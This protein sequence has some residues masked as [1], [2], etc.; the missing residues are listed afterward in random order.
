VS[1]AYRTHL[2]N[3]DGSAACGARGAV[4]LVTTNHSQITC[5]TCLKRLGLPI[6]P[7]PPRAVPPPRARPAG[8]FSSIAGVSHPNDD[9][10]SRQQIIARCR[11][12]E[13]LILRADPSN[14]YD[15]SAV[16]V[17]RSS[18]EQLGYLHAYIAPD[19][20][21]DL[22]NGIEVPCCISDLTGGYGHKYTRGVNIYIGQWEA[23]GVHS[24]AAS[25]G[26]VIVILVLLVLACI[27]FAFLSTISK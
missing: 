12:G 11:V 7:E 4:A 25:T 9:G 14:Q 20:Q 23:P 15:P 3:E 22:L 24:D 17:L 18:G 1:S 27:G 26:G 19:I 5:R 6:P 21:P 8:F 10:T 13:R 16:K 2:R